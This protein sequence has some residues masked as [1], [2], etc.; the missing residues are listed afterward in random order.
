MAGVGKGVGEGGGTP[1]SE[2]MNALGPVD[3]DLPAGPQHPGQTPANHE[4]K[5]PGT[6][7]GLPTPDPDDHSEPTL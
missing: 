3:P 2:S 1:D 7:P 6:L 5:T 4:P